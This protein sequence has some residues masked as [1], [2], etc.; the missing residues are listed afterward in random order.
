VPDRDAPPAAPGSALRRPALAYGLPTLLLLAWVAFPLVSGAATLYLRDVFATHLP[1]KAA[2]ATALRDGRLPLVDPYRALGQ[3][4]AGNPNALPFYPDDLLYLVAPVLWAFNAHFWLHLL[5]AVPA[6]AALGRAWGLSRRG[7]W[8]AGVSWGVSGFFLSQLDLYNLIAGTALTPLFAAALL[9]L[10]ESETARR[11][12]AAAAGGL[13]ALLL[14]AGDPLTAA[15]ALALGLTALAVHR[16]G[17]GGLAAALGPVALALACGTLVAAPQIVALGRIL[18]S[19]FRGVYGYSRQAATAASWDPRQ[20][21]GWLL[22]FPFG[23]PDL[24]GE[25]SFWGQRFHGGSPPLYFSLYPGL[26]PLGLVAAAVGRR[27]RAAA[28]AWGAAAVGLFFALGRFNPAAS[29]LFALPGLR[30]PVKLWLAVAV[31]GALLAGLG[32]EAAFVEERP[33][34]RRA[35]LTALAALAALLAAGWGVLAGWPGA[36]AALLRPLIPASHAASFVAAEGRRLAASCLAGA[37]LAAV[38]ALAAAAARRRPVAW[39][40]ALL[41]LHAAAQLLLLAPLY[42]TDAAAAY[43]R[44]PPLLAEIPPAAVVVQGDAGGLFGLDD[45]AGGRFPDPRASWLTRRA[46]AELYPPAGALFGRRYALDT[47]PEGLDSF[48]SRVARAAVHDSSDADRV[49]LLAAFGVDRLLLRR[50][51]ATTAARS[52]GSQTGFGGRLWV[53]EIPGALPEAVVVG[54]VEGASDLT[55][56]FHLLTRPG[57]DPRRQAVVLGEGAAR[58]GPPGEVRRLAVGPE[59]LA[60]EVASPAGGLLLWRRAWLPLYR[61][62]VDGRPA[63][64]LVANFQL[65]GLAVPAGEHRVEIRTDRRP[66]AAG[67]GLGGLGLVGLGVL[68][69]PPPGRRRRLG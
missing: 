5:L 9:R 66:L 56:A 11:R 51:L 36:A 1:L 27:H 10:G 68:L 62:A 63:P 49:R 50:P 6:M 7:A 31:G 25:G 23:R 20:L 16:R 2:A 57:F 28:W 48:Y 42:P 53:Y 35:C 3:P 4:L 12:W 59:S 41:G 58:E 54:Q 65:L 21:V 13:W 43:R 39:G 52:L 22:P 45:L 67:L 33:G 14:L 29:W 61:A 44:P 47:S 38:L 40:A 8:A 15:L 19:S 55:A 30:Y 17:R 24:I 37:A 32:F 60:A 18:G 46:L 69:L 26:L 64:L 34:A